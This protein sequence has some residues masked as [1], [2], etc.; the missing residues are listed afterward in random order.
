MSVR[1][2]RGA[3][4]IAAAMSA[5]DGQDLGGVVL[6]AGRVRSDRVGGGRVHALFYE[7]DAA[8]AAQ[9]LEGL[10][11]SARRRFGARRVVLWHRLG[12]VPV[13]QVSVIVGAACGHRAQAFEAA[14]F[15]IEELK[16]SVP[17]WKSDRARPA[18]PRPR[19]RS[20]RPGRSSG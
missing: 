18:R 12:V 2:A 6:F 15:L 1:L 11:R 17:I 20:P 16:S 4:S 14:R 9:A 5:L 13:G 19:R 10:E 3:L 8:L 7:A